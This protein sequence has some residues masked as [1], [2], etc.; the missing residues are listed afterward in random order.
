MT[1]WHIIPTT[2]H[3]L[4][5]KT[6]EKQSLYYNTNRVTHI[7]HKTKFVKSRNE[8]HDSHCTHMLGMDN[9]PNTTRALKECKPLPKRL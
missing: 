2:L 7:L 1:D 5:K 4:N 6:T 3:T 9:K 8:E